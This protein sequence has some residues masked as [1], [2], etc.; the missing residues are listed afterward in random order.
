MRILLR[1]VLFAALSLLPLLAT[2][3]GASTA[4][5]A[6]KPPRFRVLVVA[7]KA[8]DHL[9]MIAA[10]KPFFEEL[11]AKNHFAVDF[12]DD[13]DTINDENLA[14]YQVFVMLHLAPFDMTYA[15]QAAMQKFIESGKGWVGIHAAGLTGRDFLAPGTTYWEWFEAFMGGVTYSPHPAYQKGTVIVEDRKHPA[16]KHLPAKFEISDEW[17]EFNESPRQR[18]RA[19]H[20]GRDELQAE[21]A[22]GRPS[23]PLDEREVPACDLYRRRPRSV[24]ADE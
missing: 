16:T 1:A 7:S 23:D 6:N 22:D 15:Q 5:D 24:V 9:K 21:Q 19:G 10:A 14:H 20:G 11:A 12:T 18:P 13:A 2:V 17:Y 4:A 8:K 3:A